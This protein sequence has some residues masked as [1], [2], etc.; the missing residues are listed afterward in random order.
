MTTYELNYVSRIFVIC[1]LMTFGIFFCVYG[2][3]VS[4]NVLITSVGVITICSAI[5]FIINYLI[6]TYSVTE[7]LPVSDAS[8]VTISE[9]DIVNDVEQNTVDIEQNTLDVEQ[10]NQNRPI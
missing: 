4:S 5:A 6:Y 1:F 7:P 9:D 10:N 2:S 8:S 3:L